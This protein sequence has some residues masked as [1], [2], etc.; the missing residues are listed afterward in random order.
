MPRQ[1]LTCPR[2]HQ[3]EY[4]ASETLPADLSAVCPVCKA[5]D[6]TTLPP[7]ETDGAPARPTVAGYEIL[8]ELGRGGM[9][10]VY[11]ARQVGL[12]RLVALKMILAGSHAGPD[13]LA[14]FR[15]EAEA[16]ARLRHPNVV[17]VYDVGEA[18]GLPYFS[19]EFVEGG[20][21]DRKLAG[22]PLPPAEAAA[23]VEVLARAMAAAHAA[24]LVHRDLKPANVLLAADGTPKVTDFGLAKRLHAAGQ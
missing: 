17:Q 11:K 19:L 23:L 2:G 21:L 24:G 7:R 3:W 18:G 12:N 6:Q 22:T 15:G 5:A 8:A 1:T 14:R 4:T 9:G 20:N 16:V 10:V 13:D